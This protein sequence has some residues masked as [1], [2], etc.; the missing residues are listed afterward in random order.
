MRKLTVKLSQLQK[1]ELMTAMSKKRSTGIV[2]GLIG[3]L[4]LF[5]H[6]ALMLFT[7][8]L[9]GYHDSEYWVVVGF[10]IAVAGLLLLNSDR[11]N[12]DRG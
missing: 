4:F 12:G 10:I 2:L 7:N 8:L 1:L 6:L 3:T 5:L 9:R 11:K